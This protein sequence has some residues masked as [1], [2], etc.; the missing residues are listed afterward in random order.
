MALAPDQ[1]Q[2]SVHILLKQA[3][4]E[5]QVGICQVDSLFRSGQTAS[6]L[7]KPAPAQRLHLSRGIQ[8]LLARSCHTLQL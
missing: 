8:T 3:I 1:G 4:Q 7:A 6:Q 2:A 5:G